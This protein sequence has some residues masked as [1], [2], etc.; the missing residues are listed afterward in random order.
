MNIYK[1]GIDWAKRNL[2]DHGVMTNDWIMEP[3]PGSKPTWNCEICK[4][5]RIEVIAGI[6]VPLAHIASEQ[7]QASELLAKLAGEL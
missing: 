1:P 2:W 6:E 4:T 5:D 3:A 7:H